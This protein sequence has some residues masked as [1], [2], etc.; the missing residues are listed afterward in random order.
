MG[1]LRN[2]PKYITVTWTHGL[3]WYNLITDET[4]KRSSVGISS[5]QSLIIIYLFTGI[6]S[7]RM[8]CAADQTLFFAKPD[9]IGSSMY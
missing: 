7:S 1:K 4:L 3:K 5:Q 8:M 2:G 6:K 9:Q